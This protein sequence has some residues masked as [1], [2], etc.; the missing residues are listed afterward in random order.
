MIKKT[1]NKSHYQ[2]LSLSLLKLMMD[3]NIINIPGVASTLNAPESVIRDCL[4]TLEKTFGNLILEIDRTHFLFLPY[5]PYDERFFKQI[6]EKLHLKKKIAG[7]VCKNYIQ[8]NDKV[9]ISG[10]STALML[11]ASILQSKIYSL[12]VTVAGI[13]PMGVLNKY[14]RKVRIVGGEIPANRTSVRITDAYSFEKEGIRKSFI[15]FSGISYDKGLYG[16]QP[17]SYREYQA[18]LNTKDLVVFLGDHTKFGKTFDSRILTFKELDKRDIDWIVITD[19]EFES[20]EHETQ[21]L[22]EYRKFPSG[23]VK[24]C[25]RHTT[26][27]QKAGKPKGK[28]SKYYSLD[29]VIDPGFIF[30]DRMLI[31]IRNTKPEVVVNGQPLMLSGKSESLFVRIFALAASRKAGEGW[32]HRQKELFL[33]KGSQELKELRDLFDSVDIKGVPESELQ[34][35]Y[36]DNLI[37]I[38]PRKI[39]LIRLSLSQ[40]NITIEK[41]LASF[42]SIHYGALQRYVLQLEKLSLAEDKI[43]AF[44]KELNVFAMHTEM[45]ERGLNKLNLSL[46]NI[47][48]YREITKRGLAIHAKLVAEKGKELGKLAPTNW[49]FD[50]FKETLKLIQ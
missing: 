16:G 31:R 24:F 9:F 33:G 11:A 41:N 32:L 17:F 48:T 19:S 15:G 18:A 37:R 44:L 8:P 42:E 36:L 22:K 1:E 50:E 35:K 47:K 13:Y 14:L 23:R 34:K 30:K 28:M 26:P 46:G 12:D 6:Q 39:G 7:F 29:S 40:K 21:F 43:R 45:I 2:N 10:G 4:R 27:E 3:K 49:I 20:Q 38:D 25:D 5:V